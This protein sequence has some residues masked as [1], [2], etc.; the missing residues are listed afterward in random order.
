MNIAFLGITAHYLE[1]G[2]WKFRSLSIGF[3]R[4]QGSHS[5]IALARVVEDILQRFRISG[6]MQAITADSA[7]VNDT[8]FQLL[9]KNG[10]LL[11]F[12]CKDGHIQC[13]WHVINLAVQAMSKHLKATIEIDEANI[14]DN[15]NNGIPEDVE[16]AVRALYKV[17]KVKVYKNY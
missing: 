12:L 5:A 15:I 1:I 17:C 16:Q 7:T 8:M 10:R 2:T 13:V 14:A 6:A 11:G 9:E 4:L 3:E